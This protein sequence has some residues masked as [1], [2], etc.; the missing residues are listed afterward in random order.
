MSA[1]VPPS[2]NV[3]GSPTGVHQTS[4]TTT[5]PSITGSPN[6]SPNVQSTV[7]SATTTPAGGG[8]P[9]GAPGVVKSE[10]RRGRQTGLV[11]VGAFVGG[12]LAF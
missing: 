10:C 4:T 3:S 11:F 7:G 6:P 1:A 12:M 8:L 5:P 9:P 2:S